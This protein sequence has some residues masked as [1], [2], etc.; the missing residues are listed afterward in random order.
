MKNRQGNEVFGIAEYKCRSCQHSWR[1]PPGP[2]NCPKC[3]NIYCDWTNY[4]E[5]SKEYN[6]FVEEQN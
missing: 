2:I 6:S 3:R 5:W 4:E 1:E